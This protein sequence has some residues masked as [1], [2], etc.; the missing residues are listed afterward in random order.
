MSTLIPAMG[1][2]AR[3]KGISNGTI[4]SSCLATIT[5]PTDTYWEFPSA[6][7]ATSTSTSVRT[8]TT[9]PVASGTVSNCAQYA[10]YCDPGANRP[11]T[12]NTYDYIADFY[13][14]IVDELV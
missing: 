12:V 4:A 10:Q 5:L 14:I 11:N 13:G 3:L 2:S 6:M 1:V 9:L 7:D 8:Y